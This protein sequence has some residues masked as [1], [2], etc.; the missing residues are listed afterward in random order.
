MLSRRLKGLLLEG[1]QVLRT[2]GVIA[3]AQRSV[4]IL[5]YKL[6]PPTYE[7][8][9]ARYDTL[10]KSERDKLRA[11]VA[12][13]ELR[14]LISVLMPLKNINDL[15]EIRATLGSLQRQVYS[16]WELCICLETSLNN[17]IR[18]EIRKQARE[19]PRLRLAINNDD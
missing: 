6:F 13:S 7:R 8:W 12:R 11:D 17:D 10:T 19:E 4:L 9:V 15:D 5:R 3:F 18:N 1:L 14:V 2:Q 16:H